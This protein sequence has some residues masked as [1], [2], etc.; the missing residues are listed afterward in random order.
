MKCKKL[1]LFKSNSSEHL[2]T[3][4]IVTIFQVYEHKLADARPYAPIIF[5]ISWRWGGSGKLLKI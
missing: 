1:A 4:V 3:Q 5:T 2:E